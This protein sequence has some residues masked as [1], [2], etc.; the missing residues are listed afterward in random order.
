MFQIDNVKLA[1]NRHARFA[2]GQ[3][4]VFGH[5]QKIVVRKGLVRDRVASG[6]EAI[7]ALDMA[8]FGPSQFFADENAA[9]AHSSQQPSGF[10]RV[11]GDVG[12][13][14]VAVRD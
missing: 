13:M 3:V 7:A 1:G 11:A 10:V 2:V 14:D 8:T 9:R 4:G 12:A 6:L 5:V